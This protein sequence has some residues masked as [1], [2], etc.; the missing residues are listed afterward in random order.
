M[1]LVVEGAH[2]RGRYCVDVGIVKP[3]R[4]PQNKV[5]AWLALK[6]RDLLSFAEVKRITV[7]PMLLAHFLGIVHE[8]KPKFLSDRSRIHFNRRN[9]LP[10]AL[11]VLGGFSANSR[12]IV[13]N[14]L[15]RGVNVKI[16][17]ALDIRI[18]RYRS[19]NSSSPLYYDDEK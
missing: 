11:L 10:P 2:D 3:D 6:N 14:Y 5:R 1:N 16:A 13:E 12:D 18:S 4:V 17:H 15:S 19:G 9:Y 8:L 7:Y